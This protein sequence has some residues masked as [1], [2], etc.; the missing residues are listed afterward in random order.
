[1]ISAAFLPFY[2]LMGAVVGS[3]VTTAALRAVTDD[4]A[5]GHRS[6]CDGCHRPLSFVETLPVASYAM[7]RGRCG[8]CAAR[9]DPLHPIGESAGLLTGLAIGLAAPDWRGALIALLASALLASAVIDARTRILP[10]LLTLVVGIAGFS[11]A[12]LHGFERVFLGVCAALLSTLILLGLRRAFL[13]WRRDP[14]LGLGDVKLFAALSL[15]LGLAAP[16]ML[17]GAAALGLSTIAIRGTSDGKIAF[18]PMIAIAG[19]LVGLWT[20]TGLWPALS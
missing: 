8:V 7:L 10:D 5:S 11:L 19:L 15:W 9:I 16:W 1:M 17:V 13:I 6:R 4:A 14:G 2:G 18:G 3:Y 12:L 20:E